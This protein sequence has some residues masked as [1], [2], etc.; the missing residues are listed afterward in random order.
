MASNILFN[1]CISNPQH[2]HMQLLY[3]INA[4]PSFKS[5]VKQFYQVLNQSPTPASL[6]HLG[7]LSFALLM[8][9]Y[10]QKHLKQLAQEQV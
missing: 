8:P 4:H 2:R 9:E 6:A 1:S 3:L 7:A 5:K 10:P